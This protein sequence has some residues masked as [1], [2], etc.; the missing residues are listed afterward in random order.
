MPVRVFYEF[1]G[2]WWVWG[3]GCMVLWLFVEGGGVVYI[4]CWVSAG[5]ACAC[6]EDTCDCSNI[7]G[8]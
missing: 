8:L 4:I 1:N 3:D 2:V 6:V 7:M 5:H